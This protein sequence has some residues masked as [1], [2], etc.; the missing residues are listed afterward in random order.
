MKVHQLI[1]ILK[2]LEPQAEI[3]IGSQALEHPD[4]Q[5]PVRH[6]IGL[7]PAYSVEMG[8]FPHGSS[9]GD[10]NY[11]VKITASDAWGCTHFQSDNYTI[12]EIATIK[13]R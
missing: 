8:E 6:S 13:A 7:W 3:I 10:Q 12:K 11:W 1:E 2:H 9:L 4:C 5:H